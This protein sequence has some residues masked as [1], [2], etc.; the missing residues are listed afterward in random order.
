MRA[1][2]PVLLATVRV[3][4]FRTVGRAHPGLVPVLLSVTEVA[5]RLGMTR[6]GVQRRIENG[7]P[8]RG[9]DRQDLGHPG[10]SNQVVRGSYRV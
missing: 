6:G 3:A 7:T 4:P 8:R 2:S 1:R 5:E 9:Q 10:S